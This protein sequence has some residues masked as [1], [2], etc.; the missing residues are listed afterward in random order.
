MSAGASAGAAAAAAAERRRQLEEEEEMTGYRPE[1]LSQDWEFK[2]LRSATGAFKN[3]ERLRRFLEEEAHAGWVIV[4][5]FDNSRVRLKRPATARERDGKL[6]IDPYRTYVGA[7]PNVV[8]A[9]T[10][11]IVLAIVFTIILT[12]AS[13]KNGPRN[14]QIN[15]P[16]PVE[17]GRPQ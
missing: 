6:D 2:I 13:L 9:W 3:P 15:P 5:K 17:A 14:H 4:E 12:A 11:G 10:V 7:S 1:D 8:A 16:P